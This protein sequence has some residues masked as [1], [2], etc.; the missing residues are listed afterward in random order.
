[1]SNSPESKTPKWEKTG[2]F[3]RE[4]EFVDCSPHVMSRIAAT[5]N[6]E[7]AESFVR[8]LNSDGSQ[9]IGRHPDNKVEFECNLNYGSI[10]SPPGGIIIKAVQMEDKFSIYHYKGIIYFTRS[11]TDELVFVAH[12]ALDGQSLSLVKAYKNGEHEL[13][14][15]FSRRE[16]DFLFK[17]HCM[18]MIVPHPLPESLREKSI[19]EIN[20]FSFGMFGRRAW[21][22]TCDDTMGLTSGSRY[23]FPLHDT[24]KTKSGSPTDNGK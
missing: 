4:I 21:F 12:T 9:H 10:G 14:D 3:G 23:D 7:V 17:S 22:A 5:A 16:L 15:D 11:W 13:G 8:L 19:E 18:D 1:V 6:R 2:I 20:A 24:K